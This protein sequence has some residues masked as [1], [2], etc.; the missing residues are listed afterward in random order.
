MEW[1]SGNAVLRCEHACRQSAF[2]R[3]DPGGIDYRARHKIQ[4]FFP[5]SRPLRRELY[6][7][8][9]E[10]FE[11]GS[12]H[13]ER[14]FLSGNPSKIGRRKRLEVVLH[15]AGNYPTWWKGRRFSHPVAVWAAGTNAKRT[16]DI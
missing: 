13:N 5:G 11:A 14:L 9:M 6:V 15:L 4:S 3:N 16:R 10:F 12:N 7:K 8:H 1:R 2:A